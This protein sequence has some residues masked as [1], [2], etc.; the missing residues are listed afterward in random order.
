MKY[1]DMNVPV[2]YDNYSKND[3]TIDTK[4]VEQPPVNNDL[5]NSKEDQYRF[6]QCVL[7][8]LATY[9]YPVNKETASVSVGLSG[10]ATRLVPIQSWV[11]SIAD[12]AI[13][14]WRLFSDRTLSFHNNEEDYKCENKHG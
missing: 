8:P 4:P 7:E 3:S 5:K 1:T 12:R 2:I 6:Y 14:R 13:I 9:C 11:P 10:K